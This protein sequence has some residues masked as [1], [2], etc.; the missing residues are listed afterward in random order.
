MG[1]RFGKLGPWGTA[2]AMTLTVILVGAA[3]AEAQ[4]RPPTKVDP[5]NDR[6]QQFPVP[7]IR[8][9][10]VETDNLIRVPTARTQFSV[11]GTG[12]TVAVLDTG[13]RT[14]HVDF[15]GKVL[16][17]V[18]FTPNNGA[19]INDASDGQGHGTNVAG[20]AMGR[21]IHIG[22]APG[23]SVVPVKVL[24][25]TG[26]GSF[27]TISQGLDWVIQNHTQFNITVVNMSLGA[28]TNDTIDF[29]P[30]VDP[31]R[32]Q[33]QTLKA[34]R[35]PVVI[36]A[37]N[38]FFLFGGQQGM[39]YPAITRE[40]ISVGAVCDSNIGSVA[41][42]D[43]GIMFTTG[44]RRI[45]VF[46][47]RLHPSLAPAT[48]TDIFA[49][50]ATLTAA[51][52]GNDTAESMFDGTS[53]AAPVVSGLCLLMQQYA[54]RKTS[55]LPTVDQLEAWL[56]V[57][58]ANTN[59]FDGDDE[60]DNVANTF[61]NYMMADAVDMLTQEDKDIAPPPPPPPSKMTATFAAGTL[62]LTGDDNNGSLTITRRGTNAVIQCGSTTTVNG[63]SSVQFKVGSA[64]IV[65]TGDLKAGNDT[66]S[67]VQMNVSTLSTKLGA[68]NDKVVLNYTTVQM[69]QVD[70]GAGT[71]T[72]STT[73]SKITTTANINIP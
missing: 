50:G 31:I 20:V 42:F 8:A 5:P 63:K 71:D 24:D 23:A 30:T 46:S 14:T 60:D 35:I 49:P 22:I 32:A 55:Q 48:R 9:A 3:T 66:L 28:T 70:G 13:L 1:S 6:G 36:S 26:T 51:G 69:S 15:A 54:L 56:R 65:I 45:T 64:P 59:I 11:D 72:F 67:L 58:T 17:Q 61:L 39:A 18:N 29:D 21:G 4:R 52:I 25:N 68:G 37:G 41:Y 73:T 40:C 16:T 19:N 38:A 7:Q 34:L 57:S 43:G 12:L 33:I 53:Q 47:Q 10:D 2:A 27:T 44:P 62:T